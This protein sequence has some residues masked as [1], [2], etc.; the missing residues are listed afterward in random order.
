MS[1]DVK[2]ASRSFNLAIFSTEAP[3][4][5]GKDQLYKLWDV[6]LNCWV[7]VI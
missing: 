5:Q 3:L 6:E 7:R 1:T 2:L 4:G